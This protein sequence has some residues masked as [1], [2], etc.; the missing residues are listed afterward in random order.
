[1]LA[2][3]QENASFQSDFYRHKYHKILR[4]LVI[5]ILFIYLLLAVI[6]YLILFQ[7]STQYYGN[8]V[9]GKILYMPPPKVQ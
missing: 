9:D 1:M 3:R 4:W 6:F 7:P 5:S 8:T 2:S